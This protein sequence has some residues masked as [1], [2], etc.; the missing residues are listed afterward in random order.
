MWFEL[1]LLIWNWFAYITLVYINVSDIN[2]NQWSNI[3]KARSSFNQE[4][5]SKSDRMH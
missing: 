2:I 5:E 3:Q 1:S 4:V